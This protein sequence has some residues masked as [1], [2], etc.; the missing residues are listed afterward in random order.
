MEINF[1][2]EQQARNLGKS[3][4][5]KLLIRLLEDVLS[6]HCA[7]KCCKHLRLTFLAAHCASTL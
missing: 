2:F 5:I 4:V 3:R 6:N 7:V 1:D